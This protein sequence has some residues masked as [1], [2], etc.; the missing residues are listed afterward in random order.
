MPKLDNEQEEIFA[1]RMY[2][3]GLQPW[4]TKT[5]LELIDMPDKERARERI[6]ERLKELYYQQQ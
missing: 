5:A 6:E 2:N 3:R 4:L 1:Q